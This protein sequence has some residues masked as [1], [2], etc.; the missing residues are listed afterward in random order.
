MLYTCH[1]YTWSPRTYTCGPEDSTRS[2]H[3]IAGNHSG[4]LQDYPVPLT[5]LLPGC[6][7]F[8]NTLSSLLLPP[9]CRVWRA[10]VDS[11]SRKHDWVWDWSVSC[12]S[13]QQVKTA[14]Y[15]LPTNLPGPWEWNLK[16]QN[17]ETISGINKQ[18]NKVGGF[19]Y[20]CIQL[21]VF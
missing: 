7:F 14:H 2:H 3:V 8:F 21:L 6:N 12:F 11:C 19:G 1:V 18:A 20:D 17:W 16:Y 15:N 4:L 10:G 13:F 9:C 5:S